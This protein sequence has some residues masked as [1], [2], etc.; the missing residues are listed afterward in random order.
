VLIYVQSRLASLLVQ[1]F[2]Y[3]KL[4]D[5]SEVLVSRPNEG[6]RPSLALRGFLIPIINKIVYELSTAAYLRFTLSFLVL[7]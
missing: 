5:K 3:L 2:E 1:Y 6:I 7:S 4:V